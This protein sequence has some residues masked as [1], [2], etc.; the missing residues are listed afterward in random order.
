MAE[1]DDLKSS[2]CGFDPHRGHHQLTDK[3][4][5]QKAEKGEQ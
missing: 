1:A 3:K 5:N 4:V 2:K